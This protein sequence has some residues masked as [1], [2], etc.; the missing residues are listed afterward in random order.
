ML[1]VTDIHVVQRI[2]PDSFHVFCEVS[3]HLQDGLAQKR[4][5]WFSEDEYYPQGEF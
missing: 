1:F 3:K 2:H 4:H 5:S